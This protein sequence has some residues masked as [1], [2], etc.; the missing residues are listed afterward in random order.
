MNETQHT[1][2]PIKTMKLFRLVQTL[3]TNPENCEVK[4]PFMISNKYCT[5]CLRLNDS[6]L[7]N[8]IVLSQCITAFMA[9]INIQV[10]SE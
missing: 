3:I 4:I 10:S 1:T 7:W 8:V 5:A 9:T 6:S 2:D